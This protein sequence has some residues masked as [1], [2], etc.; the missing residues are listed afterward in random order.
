MIFQKGP[1]LSAAR[2]ER[3]ISYS[4]G[5]DAAT[6]VSQLRISRNIKIV[7]VVADTYV[8]MPDI[9]GDERKEATCICS[10][11][12]YSSIQSE[13]AI[14][15][16]KRNFRRRSKIKRQRLKTRE[17]EV[18][19]RW[20]TR[21]NKV[22]SRNLSSGEISK[23]IRLLN[24]FYTE[25]SIQ[26]FLHQDQETIRSDQRM[27]STRL[28]K[29]SMQTPKLPWGIKPRFRG[30]QR[31]ITEF[32]RTLDVLDLLLNADRANKC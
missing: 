28:W 23:Y 27:F 9:N 31:I 13:R 7:D 2:K 22:N 1:K 26:S 6:S 25:G 32:A 4:T 30:E 10:A 17:N 3:D 5:T 11:C 16:R 19:V 12:T 21:A 15:V 8:L 18:R 24:K 29:R 20:H 14:E